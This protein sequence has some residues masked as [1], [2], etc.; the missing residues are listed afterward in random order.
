MINGSV[1]KV[2]ANIPPILNKE[3]ITMQNRVL[4][5]F[6]A[7]ALVMSMV[8]FTACGEDEEAPPPTTENDLE[9]FELNFAIGV[10]LP[11]AYGAF[12]ESFGTDIERITNGRV[13]ITNYFGGTLGSA[14]EQLEMLKSGAAHIIYH[15]S[16]WSPGV[17]PLSE[18]P[19]L[20]FVCATPP[21]NFM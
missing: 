8:A 19:A 13:K 10:P 18:L 14:A 16:P 9:V 1:V 3:V 20:P 12:F 15:I 2:I 11:G 5:I 17:F 4:V 21:S 7:I 6:L